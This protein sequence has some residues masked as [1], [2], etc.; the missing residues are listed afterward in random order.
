G[1]GIFCMRALRWC[2]PLIV[3]ATIAA[4]CSRSSGNSSKGNS[5]TSGGGTAAVSGD[6][7]TMKSV[8]G[9]GNAKG[10]TEQGVSDTSI[11]VGTMSDPGNTTQPGLNQELFDSAD[12]F[13][14]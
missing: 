1:E 2:V 3:I 12:A 10:S 13:V 5:A 11:R 7:G 14:Q 8:C 4:G 6:F 9:P